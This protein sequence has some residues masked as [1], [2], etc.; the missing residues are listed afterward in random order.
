[1][2]G[3]LLCQPVQLGLPRSEIVSAFKEACENGHAEVA[4]RFLSVQLEAKELR[5]AAEAAASHGHLAVL[6]LL[7][8][9]EVSHRKVHTDTTD[10]SR[11]DGGASNSTDSYILSTS[12]VSQMTLRSFVHQFLKKVEIVF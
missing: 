2:I 5:A 3:L 1:M 11:F 4:G 6:K 9:Q 8:D 12:R 7:T 10:P